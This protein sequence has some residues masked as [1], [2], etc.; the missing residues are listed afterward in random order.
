MLKLWC[1]IFGHD[2]KSARSFVGEK[3]CWT[4]NE[5]VKVEGK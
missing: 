5:W 1:F 3:L 2:L 4:C